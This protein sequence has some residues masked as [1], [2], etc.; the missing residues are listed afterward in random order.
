MS[1]PA[2]SSKLSRCG[3]LSLGYFGKAWTLHSKGLL[4]RRLQYLAAGKTLA[5][6]NLPPRHGRWSSIALDDKLFSK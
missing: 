5:S 2:G 6:Q 4:Q 1:R 3:W